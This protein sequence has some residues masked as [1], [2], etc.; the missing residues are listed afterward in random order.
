MP[1][2]VSSS[3]LVLDPLPKWPAGQ[4]ITIPYET[5]KNEVLRHSPKATF[6]AAEDTA[7]VQV[8]HDVLHAAMGWTDAFLKAQGITTVEQS[9]DCDDYAVELYRTVR[10]M[11]AAA[12]IKAAPLIGTAKVFTLNPALGLQAGA[13]HRLVIARTGKGTTMAEQQTRQACAIEIY[14]NRALITSVSLV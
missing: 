3:K 12:K 9:Q 2:F 14:P 7:Y 1:F 11:A 10:R 8:P 13:M 5:L 4:L 6:D